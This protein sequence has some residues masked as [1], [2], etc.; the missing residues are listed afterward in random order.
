MQKGEKKKWV[1]PK[2]TRVGKK[3]IKKGPQAAHKLPVVA[4]VT[5]CKLRLLRMERLK[6]YLLMEEEFL[7]NQ[8]SVKPREEKDA[9]R[10][11]AT[12]P[13]VFC[14]FCVHTVHLYA[15]T[16]LYMCMHT[17]LV[18]V[19]MCMRAHLL[20]VCTFLFFMLESCVCLT[21]PVYVC[22]RVYASGAVRVGWGGGVGW[23]KCVCVYVSVCVCLVVVCIL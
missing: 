13:E 21:V 10:L 22:G 18:R 1:P 3:K 7:Q 8:E 16:Q 4:P 2:P 19:Y 6:D 11:S 17:P 5:K 20:F 14:I 12:T 9:V 23:D 15:Y